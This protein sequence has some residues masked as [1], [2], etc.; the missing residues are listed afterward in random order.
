MF[1]EHDRAGVI[2]RIAPRWFNALEDIREASRRAEAASQL[3]PF[4]RVYISKFER[5]VASILNDVA[6][7]TGTAVLLAIIVQWLGSA[8]VPGPPVQ[9]MLSS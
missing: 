4:R 3:L 8:L 5:G 9:E 7:N 1:W 6:Y 2:C